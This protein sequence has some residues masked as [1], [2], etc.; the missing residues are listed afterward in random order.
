[1]GKKMSL[2]EFFNDPQGVV[3]FG[4]GIVVSIIFLIGVAKLLYGPE[5]VLPWNR[6]E[7]DPVEYYS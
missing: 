2:I 6:E 7:E 1:M 3:I 4:F 5:M